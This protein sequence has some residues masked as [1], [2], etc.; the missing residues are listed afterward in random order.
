MPWQFSFTD[1]G[2]GIEETFF[3]KIFM[4]FKKLH[5]KSVCPGTGVGLALCKKIVEQ[6]GGDIWV[7]SVVGN[8]TTVH[9]TINKDK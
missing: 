6:H 1:N 4:L 9:F 3:D 2:I 7:E 8:G 5:P